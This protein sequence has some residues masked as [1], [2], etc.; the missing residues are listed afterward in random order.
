MSRYL[1]AV[2]SLLLTSSFAAAAPLAPLYNENADA[3]ASPTYLTNFGN[4]AIVPAGSPF[5]TKSFEFNTQ[6]NPESFFYDQIKFL[7]DDVGS[8]Y[9]GTSYKQFQISFDLFTKQLIGSAN[10]FNILLDAP[11][12]AALR[13]ENT[14][15]V[16]VQNFTYS[17]VGQHADL[18][19]RHVDLTLDLNLKRLSVALDGQEV[20]NAAASSATQLRSVRFSFGALSSDVVSDNAFVYV[21][22]IQISAA[23]PEPSTMALA[24]CVA[25]TCIARRRSGG[26]A[27]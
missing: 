8:P 6:G 5:P 17:T 15:A 18:A 22:N 16:V 2:L 24:A 4:V 25:L 26:L 19:A 13:F 9:A 20:Y 21:D 23:V 10:L 14:G 12:V 11:G 27:H 7:V 1:S 3:V